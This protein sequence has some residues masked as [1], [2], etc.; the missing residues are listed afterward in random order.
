[1]YQPATSLIAA[2]RS[3]HGVAVN[4]LSVNIDRL[5]N[6][7][8]RIITTAILYQGNFLVCCIDAAYGEALLQ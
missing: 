8:F 1:M 5:R 3:L 4:F 7:G 2:F 6:Q